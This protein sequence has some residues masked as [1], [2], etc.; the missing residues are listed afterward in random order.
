MAFTTE[1]RTVSDIFQRAARYIVPRYQRD[2]VWTVVNWK[3]L[4]TDLRFTLDNQGSIPWSHFLGTIVLNH[5]SN[6]EDGLIVY[7][8]IDGQQRLMTLYIIL[9]CIYRNYR[10]IGTEDANHLAQYIYESFLTSLSRDNNREP[11]INNSLYDYSI[12]ELVDK[13]MH[14][15]NIPDNNKL[16]K[17]FSYFDNLLQ[18]KNFSY[19][20][21][22]LD[23]V[24]SVNIVEIISGED[25]EI[26]NIFE[27]LNARGQKLRQIDLL[28][29]HIMKYVQPRA[30]S[31]IDE[32]E[33]KWRVILDNANILND[34]DYMIHHFA[35]CYI[36]KNAENKDSVY[37]L[38]KDEIDIQELGV[39][40]DKL[41]EFSERY[42]ELVSGLEHNSLTK[43]FK[44]K[45]NQQVRSLIVAIYVLLNQNIIDNSLA[46]DA[47]LQIRNFF[48][49][50]NVTRQTS[51][52][53]DS[54]ISSASYN[55][56]HCKTETHFKFI[57]TDL[58]LKCKEYI[59]GYD[60]SQVF[61]T[62]RTFQYSNV[63]HSLRRN[64]KLVRFILENV[65]NLVQID[66]CISIDE[67]TIEHLISDNGHEPSIFLWNLTL[68]SEVLNNS[69]GNRPIEEKIS[70]LKNQSSIRA[71]QMLDLYMEDQ[72][73]NFDR[74]RHDL[75]DDL[76]NHVFVLKPNIFH[77][78]SEDVERFNYIESVLK[79]ANE[80]DLLNLLYKHGKNLKHKLT[81]CLEYENLLR[82]YT[83]LFDE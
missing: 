20:S 13:S 79:E 46:N 65:Y 58:L 11:V 26:Y 12:K 16:I 54:L 33:R 47:I 67:M 43:Y 49:N 62:N 69:L 3:E 59:Q 75:L 74:R 42:K 14:S 1:N 32:A 35:K 24:L 60:L 2:Y 38:I 9:T 80:L 82:I 78:T 73:F 23:K 8:I 53:T 48:F 10:R 55:I 50:F 5:K 45:N 71:N 68:T 81:N 28:K 63:D 27:V 41:Y 25:E 72:G 34:P 4:W 83:D 17:V 6:N 18:D 30:G 37:R 76:F 77:L 36:D 29:N 57:L 31:F 44:I 52:Q 21:D 56:Y 19:I 7:E 51:N 22:F 66:N 64:A 40:L 61:T 70:I 39:F 15:E